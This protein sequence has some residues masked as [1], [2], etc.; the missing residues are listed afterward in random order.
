[1]ALHEITL[2]HNAIDVAITVNHQNAPSVWIAVLH[3]EGCSLYEWPLTSLVYERPTHKWTTN[4]TPNGKYP[5]LMFLQVAFCAETS[6]Q[7]SV[8]LVSHDAETSKLWVV[9]QIGQLQG[10]MLS[11]DEVI[12]GVIPN[13]PCL[14]PETYIFT[15]THGNGTNEALNKRIAEY[16]QY[17]RL[18]LLAPPFV[19]KAA[20]TVRYS[21]VM[22]TST[23]GTPFHK[24]F[25]F[26][27][28]DKGS[29]YADQRL[30]ARNCTSFLVTPAHLIFTTSLHLL[31]FVHM[32][33]SSEGELQI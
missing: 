33:E 6:A 30:L 25:F 20:D 32:T 4:P 5:E 24:D 31:K 21:Q 8:L 11:L 2:E 16:K 23:N 1:M 12:N 7:E 28:T 13:R 14:S 15:D 9:D 3:R 19:I 29:L 10:E 22:S 18:S 27:L 26:S 17:N